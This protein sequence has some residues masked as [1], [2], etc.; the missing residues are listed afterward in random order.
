MRITGGVFGQKAV[1]LQQ[2]DSFLDWLAKQDG[3]RN[4]AQTM[5]GAVAWAHWA[6]NLRADNIASIPYKVYTIDSDEDAEEDEQEFWLDMRQILW[7]VEMW[8]TLSGAAYIL[9][10][11]N[12]V[13]IPELQ[14]LNANTMMI[15]RVDAQTGLPALFEQRLGATTREYKA[16]DIVYFQAFDPAIDV[17]P[18]IAPGNVAGLSSSLVYNAN[19]WASQF[20]EKGAIPAVILTTDGAVPPNEKD[21]IAGAWGKMLEGVKNAFK[22]I[23]LERGLTPT[24]IG[25]P[26]KDLAM[27]ELEATKRNQI[28]AAH[29]IPPGLG[30]TKTNRSEREALQYELWTQTLIPHTDVWIEPTLNKQLFNELG[31]RIAFHPNEIEIIQAREVEKAQASS[32]IVNGVMLPMYT[33]GTVTKEE[34]RRVANVVLQAINLPALD[35]HM[36]EEEEPEPAIEE[37]L[38]EP[39]AEMGR[40]Q[41]PGEPPAPA[42]SRGL[43]EYALSDLHK[44]RE[45]CRKREKAADFNSEHIPTW[46]ADQVRGVFEVTDYQ[47]AFRFLKA[48]EPIRD[49]DEQR[50]EKEM[51]KLFKLWLPLFVDAVLAG[52]QPDY[53]GFANAIKAVL[54][55]IF[56]SIYVEQAMRASADLELP[57]DPAEIGAQAVEWA[58][59]HVNKLSGELL[60]TTKKIVDRVRIAIAESPET[61]D[62]DDIA[63][64]LLPAFSVSRAHAIALT[65]TTV[66]HNTAV[67]DVN[68][69]I[70]SLLAIAGVVSILVWHTREDERVCPIC[71]PLDLRRFDAWGADYPFGPPAHVNCRCWLEIAI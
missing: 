27:P 69:F 6:A 18:G 36:P 70:E 26:I 49:A 23:V 45:K 52:E 63:I 60:A 53:Q 16:E 48:T 12:R 35:E 59:G 7:L 43:S 21:R 57:L 29:G 46:F 22:T 56:V 58:T 68:R 19:R 62:R 1:S 30:E 71:A 32:F 37:T 13:T 9:K 24:V 31:L 33:A 54:L 14:V 50:I 28:L 61:E 5:Y 64:L 17:G 65:E 41:L 40:P 51:T 44:W 15:K 20:F 55:P 10:R 8:W 2:Y 3:N 47:E 11:R 4:D 25:Q 66:V 34:V 67:V 38:P 39:E 42:A